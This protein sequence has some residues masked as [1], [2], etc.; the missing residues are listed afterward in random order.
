MWVS[1]EAYPQCFSENKKYIIVI[2]FYSSKSRSILHKH[3]V[4]QSHKAIP[5]IYTKGGGGR[6]G[7]GK[8]N[9]KVNTEK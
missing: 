5:S 9:D 2:H 1:Q 7:G 6:R 3:D 4:L 8:N